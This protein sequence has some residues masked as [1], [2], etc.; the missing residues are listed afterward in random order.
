[1][2][3]EGKGA[4]DMV[5]KGAVLNPSQRFNACGVVKSPKSFVDEWTFIMLG[6][7]RS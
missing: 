1:M 7:G 6:E 2:S 3:F 4:L 5:N